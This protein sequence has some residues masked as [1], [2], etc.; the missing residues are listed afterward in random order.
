[1]VVPWLCDEQ[2]N[3]LDEQQKALAVSDDAHLL[4][5]AGPG[6][7]KTRVLV[8]HYLHLLMTHT[9]W[10]IEA[11]VAVTFTEKA[12][13]EMKERIGKVLQRVARDAQEKTWRDRARQ[14][15]DRLPEAPIGTIHSFCARLLRQFALAAG[16]D[17]SFQVLDDLRASIL[18][19]QVCERWLWEH[20]TQQPCDTVKDIAESVVAHWGFSRAVVILAKLLELRPLIEHRRSV[21][22]PMLCQVGTLTESEQALERCYDALVDAYEKA[23]RDINALDFDD[24]LLRTWRLLR[25]NIGAFWWTNCRTPTA[26]RWTFCGCCAVGM[27]LRAP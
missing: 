23:K 14:L 3:P 18:R 16:I 4:I 26:C 17:P 11:V 10:D 8:A 20:L 2:G 7:G 13:T 25:D 24:L 22:K 21:N 6:S 27:S 9:A 19:R 5:N 1:M 12:A 15:L